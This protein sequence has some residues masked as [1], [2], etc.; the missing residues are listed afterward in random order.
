M[1]RREDGNRVRCLLIRSFWVWRSATWTGPARAR[2]ARPRVEKILV[3]CMVVG[4]VG[5]R[6][7]ETV[8]LPRGM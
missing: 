2:L 7:P 5:Y 8:Y 3:K 1:N 6:T 4:L